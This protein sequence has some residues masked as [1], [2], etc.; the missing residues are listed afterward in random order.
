[1]LCNDRWCTPI[2]PEL[3]GLRQENQ[4]LEVSLGYTVRPHL[5]KKK[6]QTIFGVIYIVL[7]SCYCE[8]NG[9]LSF[10]IKSNLKAKISVLDFNS[11][12]LLLQM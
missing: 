7:S 9:F 1:L 11:L 5:K 12:F 8:S 4:R 3:R 10:P 2:I 6:Q